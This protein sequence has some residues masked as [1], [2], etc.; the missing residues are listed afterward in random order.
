MNCGGGESGQGCGVQQG[1][2]LPQLG[3]YP[4]YWLPTSQTV[5]GYNTGYPE[6]PTTGVQQA[7]RGPHWGKQTRD[8]TLISIHIY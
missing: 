5:L 1:G 6:F 3:K 8:A 7:A 2:K 4:K